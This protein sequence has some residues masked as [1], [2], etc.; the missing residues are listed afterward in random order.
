[1]AP[2]CSV[3]FRR[4][5]R[6]GSFPACCRPANGTPITKGPPSLSV[7]NYWPISI[8]SV[9]SKV[10]EPLVSSSWTIYG[11]QLGVCF[12][13]SSLLIGKVYVPVMHCCACPIHC[14]VH[15]RVGR[16][17]GSCRLI[18][19]QPLIGS[20]IW[21]FYIGSALWVFEVLCYLYWPSF[22]QTDHSPLSWMIVGVNWLTLYQECRW[23]AICARYCSSCTLRTFFHSGK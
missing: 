18:S 20:T 11:T 19:E 10:L 9:L 14:R 22:Y 17:L 13:P 8:T 2:R 21:A 1:M 6:L 15:S 5:V 4:L 3:L 12:Q 7:V 16:R 23:A